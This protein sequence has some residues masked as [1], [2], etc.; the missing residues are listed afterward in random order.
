[1]I[2]CDFHQPNAPLNPF[3]P[4]SCDKHLSFPGPLRLRDLTNF[5]GM[6]SIHR[7]GR[8]ARKKRIEWSKRKGEKKMYYR[9]E[10]RKG[11]RRGRK[12]AVIHSNTSSTLFPL[13]QPGKHYILQLPPET[14]L[15]NQ[16]SLSFRQLVVHTGSQLGW[17]ERGT[18][19]GEALSET[20]ASVMISCCTDGQQHF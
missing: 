5:Q 7:L 15:C 2:L 19:E 11:E 6:L 9:E 20:T 4:S 10:D 3:I 18:G 13:A 12:Q 8:R 16:S 14:G 17:R 1:M